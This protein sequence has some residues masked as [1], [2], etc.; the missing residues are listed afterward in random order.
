[1][2]RTGRA[3]CS[4]GPPGRTPARAV[5]RHPSTPSA[6][7]RRRSVPATERNDRFSESAHRMPNPVTPVGASAQARGGPYAFGAGVSQSPPRGQ[8]IARADLAHRV[9]KS[10]R[11]S[12]RSC[13]HG[14]PGVAS[15]LVGGVIDWKPG[16][17]ACFDPSHRGGRG[18]LWKRAPG[19]RGRGRHLSPEGAAPP[20]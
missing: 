5:S 13:T 3:G 1:M 19:A 2:V 14:C 12:A 6:F 8:G 4:D 18:G 17:A 11:R 20:L 10:P 16:P 9:K 15:A 7:T